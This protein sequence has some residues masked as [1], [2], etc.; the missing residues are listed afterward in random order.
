MSITKTALVSGVEVTE[1][2]TGY[3]AGATTVGFS[4]GAGTGAAADAV[5]TGAVTDI[6]I[7]TAGTDYEAGDAIVITGD[8]TGATAEVATVGAGG[9]ILTITVTAGGEGY[10]EATVESVTSTAGTGAVFGDVEITGAVT[11][12]TVTDAGSGYTSAPTVAITGDGSDATAVASI[13]FGWEKQFKFLAGKDV[14]GSTVADGKPVG[15]QH[16]G[17]VHGVDTG[18]GA[19]T[20]VENLVGGTGYT[21]PTVTIEGDGIG[22]TAEAVVDGGIITEINITNGGA[23]YSTATIVITEEDHAGDPASADAVI[24]NRVKKETISAFGSMVA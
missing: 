1:G 5:V 4:G 11:A 18:S 21:A 2:G 20:D 22:A 8:G 16:I 17:W 15:A 6:A 3:I 23:S 24:T 13:E 9:E 14:S 12:V 10:T 19:V 7:T